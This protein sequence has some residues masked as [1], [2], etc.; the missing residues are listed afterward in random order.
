VPV[1]LRVERGAP[2]DVVADVA[3][4]ID[5]DLVVL[6]SRHTDDAAAPLLSSVSRQVVRIAHRPAL[7][8]PVPTRRADSPLT[9]GPSA[10]ALQPRHVA[11]WS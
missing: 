5:A 7:V 10:A 1:N 4:A 9:G 8:L 3:A 2:E 11:L 6:A